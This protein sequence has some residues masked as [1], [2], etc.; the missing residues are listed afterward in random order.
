MSGCLKLHCF[1]PGIFVFFTPTLYLRATWNDHSSPGPWHPCGVLARLPC[2]H[3][4]VNI[5]GGFTNWCVCV[6]VCMSVFQHDGKDCTGPTVG[7]N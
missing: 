5:M 4:L 7:G 2:D 1:E 6:C 3:T